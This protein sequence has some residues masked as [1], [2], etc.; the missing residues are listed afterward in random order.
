MRDDFE[1]CARGIGIVLVVYG[2][3]LI[4]LMNADLVPA[5]HWLISTDSAIYTFH[6][7]LFFMLSGLHVERGL[8]RGRQGF[9]SSKLQSIVYPYFLWSVIQGLVQLMMSANA[10]H[11]FYPSDMLDIFWNPIGQFWFLYAL[12]LCQIFV[13]VTTTQ[14][15]RLVFIAIVAYFI[16][17]ALDA[18]I[19][20]IALKFFLFFAAG[21]L[22][23]GNLRSI[24]TRFATLRGVG[25]TFIAF[26]VAI[27]LAHGLGN[28]GTD[29]ALPET[30]LGLRT[31]PAALLGILLVCEI[32]LLISQSGK[33]AVLRV[34][35]LASMPIYLAHILA[36]S[37][38]RIALLHIHVENVYLHLLVGVACGIAFPLALYFVAGR[39]RLEKYLG[40]P[41]ARGVTFQ[42]AR[43][44]DALN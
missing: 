34:L 16:G 13:C 7:P 24:V 18:N 17:I 39:L 25:V 43:V 12:F 31:L 23:A 10:N 15:L 8:S 35:G 27:Y 11:R 26:C 44:A 40:F 38:A 42:P 41:R 36:G 19:L 14:R 4:G 20:T 22:L 37:G 5:H 6:M 1:D 29:W 21:I 30:A 3:V 32:A 9:L 28:T 2:H 33:G